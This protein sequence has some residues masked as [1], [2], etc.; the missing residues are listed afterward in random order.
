MWELHSEID[1]LKEKREIKEI[2]LNPPPPPSNFRISFKYLLISHSK[3]Q[4]TN[5]V[6]TSIT[7]SEQMQCETGKWLDWMLQIP[8][9]E[10][11]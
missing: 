4:K 5:S 2:E 7:K 9:L 3:C 10:P 8:K 6:S 1:K 11:F